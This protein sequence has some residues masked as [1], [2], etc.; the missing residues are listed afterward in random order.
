MYDFDK[1]STIMAQTASV[2]F[3]KD[4][5]E[6]SST[7]EENNLFPGLVQSGDGWSMWDRKT[8]LSRNVGGTV[9]KSELVK[10]TSLT[11]A[12]ADMYVYPNRDDKIVSGMI[13]AHGRWKHCDAL[14][15]MWNQLV[16]QKDRFQPV[17]DYYFLEIG[18]NI[19]SCLIDVLLSTNA[20]IIGFEA[21]P[22]NAVLVTNTLMAQ[23]K[24]IR[25]RVA[26]FPIGLGLVSSRDSVIYQASDNR[27]NSVVDAVIKDNDK[28][29]MLPPIP[30]VLERLDAILPPNSPI[31]ASTGNDTKSSSSKLLKLIKMDVQGF[32]C[33]VMDGGPHVFEASRGIKTEMAEKWLKNQNCSGSGLV[34]RLVKA[35]FPEKKPSWDYEVI[36]PEGRVI[37]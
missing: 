23:P 12:S 2:A 21:D 24:Y 26:F 35:G 6:E 1:Y 20:R 5:K 25:D 37:D 19:G 18:V 31:V 3:P 36:K 32:E 8:A 34:S 4:N 28:Q 22:R 13:A 7:N 30:I 15:Q 29:I 16:P 14:I 11:G 27:G 33:N 9:V 17:S 10:F